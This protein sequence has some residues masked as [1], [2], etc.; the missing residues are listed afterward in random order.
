[1]HGISNEAMQLEMIKVGTDMTF[2]S[3]L[4]AALKV[5]A[6]TKS[7]QEITEASQGVSG[8]TSQGA[9]G[10]ETHRIDSHQRCWRCNGKAHHPNNCKFKNETCFACN[11]K[12]HIRSQCKSKKQPHKQ[13]YGKKQSFHQKGG[14][15]HGPKDHRQHQLAEG[16]QSPEEPYGET[17]FGIYRCEAVQ[18]TCTNIDNYS[19]DDIFDDVYNVRVQPYIVDVK[20]AGRNVSM[21]LDTG[22]SRS[23]ISEKVYYKFFSDRPLQNTNVVLRSYCNEIIPMLGVLTVPVAYKDQSFELKLIVVKGDRPALLGRD[24]LRY[25][26]LD[27]K[28]IFS[29]SE[30][31]LPSVNNKE[32]RKASSVYPSGFEKILENFE[33]VF[34]PNN[35][36]IKD[37]RASSKLKPNSMPVFQ[38]ARPVPYSMVDLVEKEYERLVRAGVM[39]SVDYSEWGTP[40][41][42]VT[43]AKGGVRVC[44]DYKAINELI[45]DDGYKLPNIQ[46]LFAKL[47]QGGD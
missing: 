14:H 33:S 13:E 37:L 35:L 24:W 43:K 8:V 32:S 47:A 16:E 28:G 1:M 12:G 39:Y 5:E 26:K 21:E 18:D 42:N 7:V 6:T 45:E 11:K 4:Q 10:G 27:W 23:T 46:D 15:A 41:V 38:K 3:G 2:E 40:V 31:T 9:S 34:K 19:C 30:T 36:G 44:G 20:V 25:V 29:G 17:A 22:A